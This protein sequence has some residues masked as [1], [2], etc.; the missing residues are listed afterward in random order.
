PIACTPPDLH[1]CAPGDT[2]D[3]LNPNRRRCRTDCTFCGDGVLQ[4]GEECD[5]GVKNGPGQGCSVTCKTTGNT[6]TS[7]TSPPPSTTTSLPTVPATTRLGTS[8]RCTIDAGLR[9]LP[10]A[11]RTVPASVTKKFDQAMN[12]IDQAATSPPEQAT[13]LLK[14]AK[15]AL[16]QAE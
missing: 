11:G 15:R 13:K 3:N 8:A 12:L 1:N 2:C 4:Q 14:K 6:S 16:K 7:T 9:S 10:C 5:N